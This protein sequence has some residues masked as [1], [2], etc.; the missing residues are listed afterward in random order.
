MVDEATEQES[1][2]EVAGQNQRVV[3]RLITE[4]DQLEVGRKYWVKE[5]HF[6]T[7]I[8]N[9]RVCEDHPEG[10]KYFG[11]GNTWASESNPQAFRR[12]HI[13]GPI[14]ELTKPDWDEILG[15]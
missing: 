8:D 11:P 15:T 5:K 9:I 12:W 13:Y 2:A 10:G 7:S 6:E 3:M 4:T 1:N 14:P